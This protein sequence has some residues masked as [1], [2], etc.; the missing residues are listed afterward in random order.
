MNYCFMHKNDC[1]NS[2]FQALSECIPKLRSHVDTLVLQLHE[3]FSALHYM[4]QLRCGILV[5]Y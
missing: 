5:V 2:S 3:D 4:L 1:F